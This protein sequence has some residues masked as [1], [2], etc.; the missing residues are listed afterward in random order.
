MINYDASGNCG[1]FELLML[2]MHMV[3]HR[4]AGSR[5][6]LHVQEVDRNQVGKVG[7]AGSHEQLNTDLTKL[8]QSEQ[9]PQHS[10]QLAGVTSKAVGARVECD[11]I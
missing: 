10:R 2:V 5:V 1:K 11:A 7:H 6:C 9:T 3:P 4:S 8:D